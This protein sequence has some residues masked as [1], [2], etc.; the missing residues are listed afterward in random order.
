MTPP[1]YFLNPFLALSGD[2]A[3]NK[4][5]SNEL[6]VYDGLQR[7]KCLNPPALT[8]TSAVMTVLRP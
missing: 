7:K 8:T 6:N 3:N 1:V 2:E 5:K 4:N